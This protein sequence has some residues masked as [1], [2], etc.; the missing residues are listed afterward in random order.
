MN[1]LFFVGSFLGMIGLSSYVVFRV[2][3]AIGLLKGTSALIAIVIMVLLPLSLVITM[4]IGR[5]TW[6]P[7]IQYFY[8]PGAVW[9]PYLLYLF[10][11][12][13]IV[14]I[15]YFISVKY[16]LRLPVKEIGFGVFLL[17]NILIAY[18]LINARNPHV[19]TYEINSKEL[20]ENWRGKKIILVADTHL[21]IIWREKFMSKVVS[22]INSE[23]PDIVLLAGDIIDGPK[24]P[25]IKGLEPLRNIQSTFGTIFTPG[26]HEGYNSDP[27]SFY[28]VISSLTNSLIDTQV[29][30]NN[31]QIIGL[32]YKA[33]ESKEQILKRL[34][35]TGFSKEKPSIVLLHDP[36][37]SHYLQD[38]GVSLVVSGHTHCG[39]FWPVSAIVKKM[40]GEYTHGVVEKNGKIH[41]TTCGAGTAMSPVRIGTTPEIVVIKVK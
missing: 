32:D 7:I 22:L 15:A 8:I 21:G 1:I 2:G 14:G 3:Q 10:I 19:L 35:L 39:Q 12:S 26:N 38:A 30:I 36:K 6:N 23:N 33:Q 13:T 18:G 16:S 11:G 34:D 29:T 27:Q 4:S 37:N 9:L 17:V 24:F 25:Y 31:T 41:I 40:Y 20:S 5:S 28:P